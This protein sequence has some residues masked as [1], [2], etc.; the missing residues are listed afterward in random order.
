MLLCSL[1]TL[2]PLPLLNRL[3]PDETPA[4]SVE[5]FVDAESQ[6]RRG[7]DDKD[8]RLLAEGIK[9]ADVHSR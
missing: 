1:S 8:R 6:R 9:D 5:S 4:L 3:V 7:A 2:L